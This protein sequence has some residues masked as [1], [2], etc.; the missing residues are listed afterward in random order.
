MKRTALASLAL[1]AACGG[2]GANAALSH[3]FSYGAPQPATSS[4][5]S[6]A[7]SAQTSLSS[8]AS[9]STSPS[10]D[11]GYSVLDFAAVLSDAALGSSG[12]VMPRGTKSP[13]SALRSMA[14]ISTCTTVAG[15]TVT[16]SNCSDS[17]TGFAITLNGSITAAA[18]VVSWGI[19]GNFSGS[20]NNESFNIDI[21]EGGNFTITASQVTGNATYGIGGSASAQGTSISFGLDAATLVD[22][23]FQ[24]TPSFCVTTGDVEVKRVWTQVPQGATATDAGVKIG[25]SACNGAVTVAHSQ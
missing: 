24:T 19:T 10:A 9:F 20:E 11:K 12:F 5:A 2:N 22:L 21:N 7:A 15:N 3:T 23:A 4:E 6:A 13:S 14:D 18:G 17:S 1:L 8:A 25:W 16:F